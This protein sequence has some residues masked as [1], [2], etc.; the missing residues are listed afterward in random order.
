MKSTTLSL[1]IFFL[2]AVLAAAGC[3]S[4]NTAEKSPVNENGKVDI[5]V[6]SRYVPVK[7]D[8]MPLTEFV[9]VGNDPDASQI[10]LYVSLLDSFGS[11][12]KAP[13]VFRFELYGYEKLRSEPKGKRIV[14]WPD[15]DLTEPGINNEYWRDFLRAYEFN[16]DFELLRNQNYILQATCLCP[17]GRR[18]S[19]DFTLKCTN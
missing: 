2:A 14:I 16:L 19:T 11:Q 8:I 13:A 3:D 12:I 5:S 18:L 6:Y 7:I 15:I 10:N 17:N 9:C 1:R 4:Q